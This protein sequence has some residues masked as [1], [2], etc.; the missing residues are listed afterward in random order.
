MVFSPLLAARASIRYLCKTMCWIETLHRPAVEQFRL[1]LGKKT[2]DSPRDFCFLVPTQTFR[3]PPLTAP[4]TAPN[5][6]NERRWGERPSAPQDHHPSTSLV[7][8]RPDDPSRK[9]GH[10]PYHVCRVWKLWRIRKGKGKREG[11]NKSGPLPSPVFVCV[12][13]F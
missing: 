11:R 6:R 10:T 2:R 13:C 1:P 12:V 5:S 3:G 7:I 4:P 9:W 8:C